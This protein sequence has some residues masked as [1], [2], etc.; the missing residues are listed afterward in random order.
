MAAL[1]GSTVIIYLYTYGVPFLLCR[2]YHRRKGG[3][4]SINS[5]EFVENVAE[6]ARKHTLYFKNL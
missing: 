5:G 6:R 4:G 3:A 2:F 1:V